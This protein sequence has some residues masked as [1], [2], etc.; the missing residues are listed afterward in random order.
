MRDRVS[1]RVVAIVLA[2]P[3]PFQANQSH[4]DRDSAPAPGLPNN[5]PGKTCRSLHRTLLSNRAVQTEASE[6]ALHDCF[7]PQRA[8]GVALFTP[9]AKAMAKREAET[10][11]TAEWLN[12]RAP[13]W[14]RGIRK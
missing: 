9:T 11:H 4:A 8:S 6:V 13:A 10:G 12:C 3:F 1:Q 5:L 14:S 7:H 2:Q